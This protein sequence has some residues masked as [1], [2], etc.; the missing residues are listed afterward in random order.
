LV[1]NFSFVA[2]E[3]N[4]FDP[5]TGALLGHPGRR[6][7]QRCG[8]TVGS[9]LRERR[10]RRSSQHALSPMGSPAKRMDRLPPSRPSRSRRAWLYWRRQLAFSGSAAPEEHVPRTRSGGSSRRRRQ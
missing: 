7:R 4:A 6:R 8:R 3:I 9:D 5:I 10:E 2:S 1:G